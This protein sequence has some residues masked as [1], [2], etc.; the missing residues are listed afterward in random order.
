[1]RVHLTFAI[2]LATLASVVSAQPRETLTAKDIAE[3][4]EW[5]LHG[6]PT[7]YLI[8]NFQREPDVVNQGVMAVL[9]TPFL[10]VALAAKAAATVGDTFEPDDVTDEIIA[11]VFYVAFRWYCCVDLLHGDRENWHPRTPPFN[12]KIAEPGDPAAQLRGL[13]TQKP[14]WVTRELTPL[15]GL[16][17]LP[18]DDLVL[19]AGYPM[20]ALRTHRTYAI[21]QDYP[22]PD[23]PD[24]KG[25]GA[26]VGRVTPEDL[27]R[28]G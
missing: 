4:I 2:I 19:I 18:Y 23:F 25:F 28:W 22:S 16:G 9:Y 21:Y 3:A 15:N 11:P 13:V 14:L 7:P 20:S 10:R 5:G 12:Y 6:E 8:H 26:V 27:K 1:M 24:K 17:E